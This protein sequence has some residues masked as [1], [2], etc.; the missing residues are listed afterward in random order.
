MIYTTLH[1]VNYKPNDI[2]MLVAVHTLVDT[3]RNRYN[4]LV[5]SNVAISH[6]IFTKFGTDVFQNKT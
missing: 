3:K 2:E 4:M 5:L 6:W 1:E